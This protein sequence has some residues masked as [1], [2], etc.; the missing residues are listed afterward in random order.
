MQ[1]LTDTLHVPDELTTVRIELAHN[2]AALCIITERGPMR[3]AA[4][5]SSWTAARQIRTKEPGIVNA[6]LVPAYCAARGID[7]TDGLA[8]LW[9][10]A[11][12]KW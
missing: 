12:R 6:C 5:A 10:T 11:V 9:V 2:G 1:R 3:Q 7:H 4:I 8:A